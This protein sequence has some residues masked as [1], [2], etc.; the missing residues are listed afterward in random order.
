MDWQT[1]RQMLESIIANP[2][3]RDQLAQE[4]RCNK[5]TLIRWARNSATPRRTMLPLLIKAIREPLR[6][7]FLELLALEFPDVATMATIEDEPEIEAIPSAFYDSVIQAYIES[8]PEQRFF[9]VANRVFRQALTLLDTH[10]YGMSIS[11]AQC[12]PPAAGEEK[13]RSLRETFGL[14]TP[15]WSAVLS[16]EALFLG[17]ESLAGYCVT[18]G[19]S[20]TVNTRE[21]EPEFLPVRWEVWERS[22]V[23]V[24][25][26]FEQ[27]IAGCVIAS[28]TTPNN[29]GPEQVELLG[30][31]AR[32][33]V[34]AIPGEQFYHPADIALAIMPAYDIQ[35]QVIAG[36]PQRL[37]HLLREASRTGGSL[38]VTEAEQQVWKSMEEEL[39]RYQI[40]QLSAISS[41]NK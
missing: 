3:E 40:E 24:P 10:H 12:I 37:S 19:R 5:L 41:Q 9:T 30:Q 17:I 35:R 11:L 2:G 32:L 23:A 39:I 15:P 34:L 16:S 27:R 14:G 18:N 20:F 31:F 6:P 22:A 36:F 21:E 25:L 29:W 1:W 13:V 7:R 38:R 33:L 28:S 8:R 26:W 4:L